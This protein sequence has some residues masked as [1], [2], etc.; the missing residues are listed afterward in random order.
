MNFALTDWKTYY[1]SL[2]F[3]TNWNQHWFIILVAQ[4]LTHLLQQQCFD[5]LHLVHE[6]FSW[7]VDYKVELSTFF[8]QF[9]CFQNWISLKTTALTILVQSFIFQ[10]EYFK[11]YGN[12]SKTQVFKH[13]FVF[14]SL[15]I[16]KQTYQYILKF[17]VIF[18]YFKKTILLF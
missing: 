1:S 2:N 9:S 12:P 10:R 5:L 15:W 7:N 13:S 4:N 8:V 18:Y 11:C 17:I 14:L 16:S 6:F 3:L